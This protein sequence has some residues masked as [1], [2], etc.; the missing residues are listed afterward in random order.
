MSAAT[1][2][3]GIRIAAGAAPLMLP[4]AGSYVCF[5]GGAQPTAREWIAMEALR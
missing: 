4:H 1:R 5:A 2:P 3:G